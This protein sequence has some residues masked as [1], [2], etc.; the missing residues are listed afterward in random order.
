MTYKL[1]WLN[2]DMRHAHDM[3]TGIRL[4]AWNLATCDPNEKPNI[5]NLFLF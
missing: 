3:G 5:L 4:L 1:Q 2:Y